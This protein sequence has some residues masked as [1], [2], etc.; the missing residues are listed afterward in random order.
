MNK[1]KA[2]QKRKQAVKRTK[3]GIKKELKKHKQNKGTKLMSTKLGEPQS[4]FQNCWSQK[5]KKQK[6][7]KKSKKKL[8]PRF[9]FSIEK[10]FCYKITLLYIQ[11]LDTCRQFSIHYHVNLGLVIPNK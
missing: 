2:T 8:S 7:E 3:Q 5:G 9:F 1:K 11:L 6:E 4:D 10:T